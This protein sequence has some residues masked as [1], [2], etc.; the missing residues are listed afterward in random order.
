M[1]EFSVTSNIVKL[2]L[3]EAKKHEAKKV[4][5]VHLV[6]GKLTFLAV[7]QI[8]F[9]YDLIVKNTLMEGSKLEIEQRDGTVECSNCGYNGPINIE[10]DP[11]YH[12]SFPSLLCPKCGSIAKIVEGKECIVKNIRLEV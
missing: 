12:F 1:H 9:S 7:E 8:K 11:I 5:E 6:I 4:L 2:V 10:E 3:E